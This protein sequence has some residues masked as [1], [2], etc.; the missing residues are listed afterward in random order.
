M[1]CVLQERRPIIPCRGSHPP[2]S[3]AIRGFPSFPLMALSPFLRRY[4]LSVYRLCTCGALM[5]KRGR[6]ANCQRDQR[7]SSAQRGYGAQWRKGLRRRQL[8][9]EP[10]CQWTEGEKRCTRQATDVDHIV[11]KAVGGADALD[12]LQSLCHEHHSAKTARE[13]RWQGR[14]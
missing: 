11:R 1:S 13:V 14:K 2:R 6:C 5:P 4:A 8:Q 7:P 10:L 9:R 3:R 12:N